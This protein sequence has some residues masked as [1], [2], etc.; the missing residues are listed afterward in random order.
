[1]VHHVD[2]Y[3]HGIL[4]GSLHFHVRAPNQCDGQLAHEHHALVKGGSRERLH[5]YRDEQRVLYELVHDDDR[6]LNNFH[7]YQS[8]GPHRGLDDDH[9]DG[10]FHEERQD[11]VRLDEVL[12]GE[13]RHDE[14]RHD[15]V[16]HDE[17]LHDEVLHDEVPLMLKIQSEVLRGACAQNELHHDVQVHNEVRRGARH[18]SAGLRGVHL[19]DELPHGV[20]LQSK[21]LH[22]EES[23]NE[24]HDDV[25]LQD[26]ATHGVAN[27]DVEQPHDDA[28]Q[29]QL[30]GVIFHEKKIHD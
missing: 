11:V 27:H 30:L 4:D 25:A 18:Q 7:V 6:N 14:V 3:N 15:E 21:L 10:P 9:H 1:M 24:V 16:L 8:N 5:E 12:H 23:M 19:R 28:Q 17:V 29:V 13:V 2:M 26:E 22:D 20:R